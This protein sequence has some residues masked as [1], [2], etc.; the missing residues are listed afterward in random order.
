MCQDKKFASYSQLLLY[1]NRKLTLKA[2]KSKGC[3]DDEADRAR[4]LKLKDEQEK[5]ALLQKRAR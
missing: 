1:E 5:F 3:Y 4:R 2:I